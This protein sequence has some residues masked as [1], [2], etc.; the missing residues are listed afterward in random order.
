[1]YCS[2]GPAAFAAVDVLVVGDRRAAFA[3]RRRAHGRGSV[4]SGDSGTGRVRRADWR[5]E[6]HQRARRSHGGLMTEQADGGEGPM[7]AGSHSVAEFDWPSPEVLNCSSK[8]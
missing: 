1:M 7:H 5:A 3:A 6:Q 4:A 2:D 8:G